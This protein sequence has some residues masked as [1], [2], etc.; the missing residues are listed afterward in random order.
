MSPWFKIALDFDNSLAANWSVENMNPD[1]TPGV[2]YVGVSR[3][4]KKKM[5]DARGRI[6]FY[7][8]KSIQ[9]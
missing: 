7:N 9:V 4:K 2:E 3:K 1:M 6:T 8:R 5:S